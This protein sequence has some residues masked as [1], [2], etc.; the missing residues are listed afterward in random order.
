MQQGLVRA[1]AH[2]VCMP[3][4]AREHVSKRGFCFTWVL[5]GFHLAASGQGQEHQGDL[6]GGHCS[7]PGQR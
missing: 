5:G 7:S 6:P 3:Q 4:E 2:S 1:Q